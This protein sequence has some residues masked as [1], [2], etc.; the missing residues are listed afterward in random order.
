[1]DLLSKKKKKNG[2]GNGMVVVSPFLR[3][4]ICYVDV[5]CVNRDATSKYIPPYSATRVRLLGRG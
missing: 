4:L 5:K 2:D 1:M 3:V